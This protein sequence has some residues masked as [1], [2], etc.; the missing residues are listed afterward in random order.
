MKDAAGTSALPLGSTT[1]AESASPEMHGQRKKNLVCIIGGGGTGAALAY[2]LALRGVGVLL[3]ERGE[4]T[5][6]TTGRH[7]GQIHSGARYAVA[8]RE[9]ARE[10]YTESLIMR[11]IVPEAVEYNGGLF[12]ALSDEDAEWEPTFLAALAEAGIPALRLTADKARNL[13]PALPDSLKLAV[14][15]PDG[16][17][18]AYRVPLS[19]FAA[20]ALQG[21]VVR[22]FCEVVGFERSAGRITRVCIVDR[23]SSP[24]REE[25]ISVDYVVNATGAWAGEI[26][27]LAGIDIPVT[28]A[29]GAMLAVRGRLCDHVL[30]R[31]RSA[32][33]G[34]ILVP[35]RGLSIIGST[36]RSAPCADAILPTREELE[37]LLQAGTEIVK[38]FRESPFHA[39][40]AAARPL[41][42]KKSDADG[43]SLSRDFSVLDHE[44]EGCAGFMSIT[45]GKATVLR[46]MGEKAADL[47][48]KK[49][50]I[51]A[52]CRTD[53][54]I[55]P[56]WREFHKTFS[57]DPG[58]RRA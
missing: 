50:G 37:F 34:D 5:S 30:S 31:L 29:P 23:S 49:L 28:P 33:D 56:S 54:Y 57:R 48:C 43:R 9:I 26:G 22:P 32:G 2:D 20:A 25:S 39:V 24:P 51:Q 42:G 13:E 1:P 11:K 14:R 27:K 53:R 6:G 44:P 45:G 35:Q 7:H 18:D 17:F 41:A 46:A 16:T 40:W 3:L 21:A 36:Q 55:L 15:V 12:L 10:C 4:L 38:G 52:E 47:V 8:D 19:F 58:H